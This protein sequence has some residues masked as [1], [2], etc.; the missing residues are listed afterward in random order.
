LNRATFIRLAGGTLAGLVSLACDSRSRPKDKNVPAGIEWNLGANPFID[1]APRVASRDPVLHYHQ[2][3]LRCYYTA[4]DGAGLFVDEIHSSDFIT[5]SEPRRLTGPGLNFSSPGNVIRVG[6]RWILCVQSYPILPGEKY[7]S[8]ES[9]LWLMS[10]DNLVDWSEPEQINPDG[11][12]GTWTDSPRQIDPYLVSWQDQ[13]W[14]FYKTS[15]CLGLLVSGDLRNW[16]EAI[17]DRPVISRDRTPDG[18]TVENPCVIHD[19]ESFVM[20]FARVGRER[21]I[22]VARSSN[23]TDWEDIRYLEFPDLAWADSGPTAAMVIDLRDSHG[24]WL[25][26]FHGERDDDVHG[27]AALGLAISTDL[28]NW[29]LV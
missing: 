27:K 26:A 24:F 20:F 23:L 5:W 3:V 9:R 4:V 22:G 16:S 17:P 13:Y 6:D 7:G 19:G 1:R 25:M 29:E 2:G 10:S 18:A 15:G 21:G 8:E 12:R 28:E 11:C 14:C